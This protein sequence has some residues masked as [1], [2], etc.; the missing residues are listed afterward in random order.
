MTEPLA[1]TADQ[2]G[3]LFRDPAL[4]VACVL[5]IVVSL[6]WIV[7]SR[8]IVRRLKKAVRR[9]QHIATRELVQAPRDIWSLPPERH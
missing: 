3:E 8:L 7:V 6:G 2:I 5:L 1:A 4:T 9:G